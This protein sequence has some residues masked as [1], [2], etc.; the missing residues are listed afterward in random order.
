MTFM[1]FDSRIIII[2]FVF[3]IVLVVV[4]WRRKRDEINW[5]EMLISTILLG[6]IIAGAID[7]LLVPR[8]TFLSI[9]DGTDSFL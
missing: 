3:L 1:S 8:R 4:L 6:V 7:R 5:S 9:V 2:S